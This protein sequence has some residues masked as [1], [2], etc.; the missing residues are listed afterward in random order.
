MKIRGKCDNLYTCHD[1]GGIDA[2]RSVA[3]VGMPP[4]CVSSRRKDS[5][6]IAPQLITKAHSENG[7]FVFGKYFSHSGN[8]FGDDKKKCPRK[9]SGNFQN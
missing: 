9:N 3:S 1:F 6:G 5:D 4:G 7:S 8:I 2:S